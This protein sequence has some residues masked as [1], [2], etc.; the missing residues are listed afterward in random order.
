[1]E[2]ELAMITQVMRGGPACVMECLDLFC[3]PMLLPLSHWIS[4]PSHPQ[5]CPAQHKIGWGQHLLCSE[6][7]NS[8]FIGNASSLALHWLLFHLCVNPNK[9]PLPQ[10]RPLSP[11]GGHTGFQRPDGLVQ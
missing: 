10:A 11:L 9:I 2:S 7:S 5:E 4:Y 6:F 3:H 8:A 1:M